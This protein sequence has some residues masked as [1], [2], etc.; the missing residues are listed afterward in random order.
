MNVV[1]AG[2]HGTVGNS[3]VKSFLDRPGTNVTTISRRRV[4]VDGCRHLA[5]DLL[6]PQA[7]QAS[8]AVLQQ[9]EFLVFAARAPG[10]DAAHEAEVNLSMLRNLVC[11]VDG[12]RTKLQR[13]VLIHGTKWYGCHVGPYRIPASEGD[14]R[15]P[16]PL[17]YF[18]QYDWL[19]QRR[20]GRDWSMATLRPHTV[21]GYSEGTPNNLV[22]LVAAYASL[23]RARGLPLHFPGPEATYRKQSQGTDA[24]LLGEGAVWACTSPNAANSDFNLTNGDTFSWASLWPRIAE[25]FGMTVGEPGQCTFASAFGEAQTVWQDLHCRHSLAHPRLADIASPAYGD[26]L[27]ACTWDDVSSTEAARAA[28]W[29]QALSSEE[30]L[31]R[32]LDALRRDRI[33]P[34]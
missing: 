16:R 1:I 23:Q 34:Q 24:G 3:L 8:Q 6:D 5:I 20:S 12:P 17:F 11:A 28:G 26:G 4:K 25:A 9:C 30:T 32:I 31:L 27:F 15:G 13:T 7:L 18:D 10:R 22:T 14:L 2:A 33:V 29:T 21:W 19:A